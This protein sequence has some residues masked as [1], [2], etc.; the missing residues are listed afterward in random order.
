MSLVKARVVNQTTFRVGRYWSD[1][2]LEHKSS[3]IIVPVA[4]L[5]LFQLKRRAL[6]AAV[7]AEGQ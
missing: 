5:R 7:E 6:L 1:G 2:D 4:V 3:A